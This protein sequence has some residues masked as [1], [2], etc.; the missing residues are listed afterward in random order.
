MS[1]KAKPDASKESF[2]TADD[3]E[4]FFKSLRE[5][6]G[7]GVPFGGGSEATANA[8][9]GKKQMVTSFFNNLL[10]KQ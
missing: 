10:N 4:S 2:V 6:L 1:Q 5:Q 7:K 3:N 8:S 9:A